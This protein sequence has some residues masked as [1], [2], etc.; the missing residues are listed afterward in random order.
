DYPAVAALRDLAAD[1]R[2]VVGSGVEMSYAADWT[3]YGAHV[4]GGDVSFP[5]DA[6]WADTAIDYVGLDW[7]PPMADWRD[8]A[9]HADAGWGDGRSRAYLAA[10][11]AGGEAFDWYYAGAAG[12]S[13]QERLAITDGAWGEP[14][15]FRQKDVAGWWAH[16]HHP[17]SAGVR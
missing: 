11:V 17:R 7:Y 1:V 9:D 6:L 14:F 8:G 16:A 12:R 4:A 3:E 2:A 5:L 10:N 15:V 13:A